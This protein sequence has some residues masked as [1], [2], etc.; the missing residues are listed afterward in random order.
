MVIYGLPYFVMPD[1]LVKDERIRHYEI[2]L[3]AVMASHAHGEK[4]TCNPSMRRLS[5][6]L[7]CSTKTV[8]RA[9]KTLEDTGW[10]EVKRE[11]SEDGS[12]LPNEYRLMSDGFLQGGGCRPG[13]TGGTPSRNTEEIQ[14]LNNTRGGD[15]KAP[16]VVTH[17][18]EAWKVYPRKVGK[19]A[20][21]KAYIARIRKGVHQDDL[22]RAT[23]NY[24]TAMKKSG[25]EERFIKHGSTFFGPDDHWKDWVE[26]SDHKTESGETVKVT[27]PDCNIEF[28]MDATEKHLTPCPKCGLSVQWFSESKEMRDRIRNG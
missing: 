19:Q 21:L 20:A 27:C 17:F 16:R 28:T 11:K 25:T 2:A 26:V 12:N 23:K 8:D 15:R 10:I 13:K 5:S 3:Y 1:G 24:A 18:E 9:I 4:D 7:G 22:L 14:V 6:L